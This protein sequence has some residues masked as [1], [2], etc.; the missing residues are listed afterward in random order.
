MRC[1]VTGATGHI[2]SH[3][4]RHLLECNV[5]V[6]ALVRPTTNNLWRIE[7]VIS[8][9]CIIS[10]DLSNIELSCA[11]IREFAPE[12]VFHLGWYGVGGRHRDDVAQL[13][14]NLYGSIDLLCLAYE[15]GCKR[16]VGLGSQAEYGAYNGILTEDLPTHP[17]TFYGTAKLCVCLLSQKLCEA[18]KIGFV[19]LRLLASY[20]PMDDVKHIISYVIVSLL[21]GQKPD[22][23][24]GEQLWD[25]LYVEDAIRAMW[26]LAINRKAQG[27]FN[28]ASGETHT[29]RSIVETVRDLIDPNLPLGF[30]EIPYRP[31]QIM[32]LQADVSR[33]RE[34]TG[35]SPQVSIDE[36]LRR[37]VEWFKEN[38]WRHRC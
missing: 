15:S 30:G 9:L 4:V 38:S 32:H 6:A 21:R 5:E 26:Q 37:T 2:G 12:V 19:W 25:Y 11:A 29:I 24:L 7:D 27:I 35:W 23:T 28:L 16:W 3:L 17:T 31:N 22:L 10:G 33:L 1:L 8:R 34:V 13:T 18:Y 14:Q 20:G 36:G